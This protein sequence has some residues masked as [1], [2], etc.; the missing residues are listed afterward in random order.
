MDSVFGAFSHNMRHVHRRISLQG[1][2]T[3]SNATQRNRESMHIWLFECIV[4]VQDLDE[5]LVTLRE[6]ASMLLSLLKQSG[7]LQMRK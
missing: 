5:F 6:C 2:S 7:F 3:L 1:V 4:V